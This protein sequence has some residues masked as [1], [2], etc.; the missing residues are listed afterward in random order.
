MRARAFATFLVLWIVAMAG[1]LVSHI[2]GTS[3]RQAVSG[4]EQLAAVRAKWAARAG[5]EA[6]IARLGYNTEHPDQS[7]AFRVN[8][9]MAEVA[10]ST[11]DGADWVISH[12]TK[13]GVLAGPAD[14]HAKCNVSRMTVQSLMYIP[15]MTEDVA[16]SILDWVDADDDAQPYGAEVSY[17][18]R[19]DHPYEPRNAP[20]RT[21]TELE[22][23]AGT[24]PVVVRGEDWDLD[25]QLDPDENDGGASWPDDN[26]DN[27]LDAG[28]SAHLTAASWEGSA[29][30]ASGEPI[31][32]LTAA[33]AG[34]L[35]TRLGVDATQAN[36]ILAHALTPGA[37]LADFLTTTLA[38]LAQNAGA[39]DR[40]S[41]QPADL[42]DDQLALILDETSIGPPQPSPGKLNINT[43]E[44]ETLEYVPGMTIALSDA[45]VADR[46]GRQSGYTSLMDLLQ[47]P[48][49]TRQV[50][51]QLYP[52][53]T[54]RSNV[55]VVA[56]RGRDRATGIEVELVATIDR[57]TLPITI[58]E[59]TVR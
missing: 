33:G 36:A 46:A 41:P 22:L 50:L 18:Q 17:Y 27:V 53:I 10:Y 31:L 23:V 14:A 4:R 52:Y 12:E 42:T 29:Y 26:A 20:M 3:F 58:R 2:Q 54:V 38:Q 55:Y 43:A 59:I 51:A 15:L 40:Q 45:I 44:D 48:G 47:I 34:D 39:L 19:A 30:G 7:D 8:D 57:S 13:N 25:D 49:F 11:L 28:W 6:T 24:D 37:S 32:D 5:I 1:I 35:T 9:D 56:S 21:I 16:Q